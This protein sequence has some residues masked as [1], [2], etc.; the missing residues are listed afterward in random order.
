MKIKILTALTV[1]LALLGA[2]CGWR[3]YRDA[4]LPNRQVTDALNTQKEL[5]EQLRPNIGLTEAPADRALERAARPDD[6]MPRKGGAADENA[7]ARE[8]FAALAEFNPDTVGWLTIDGTAVDY[9]IVQAEDNERYL[10][11][12]FDRRYNYVGCPFLDCRCA[13]GFGGFNAIVYA[14]HIKHE[15]FGDVAKFK[16]SAFMRGHPSAALLTEDGLHTVEFF[17]Y[18]NVPSDSGIYETVFASDEE[19][20]EY[21]DALFAEAVYTAGLT[22]EELKQGGQAHILLLST[23]T[24]EFEEA[25]GVLAGVIR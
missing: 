19:R 9:P 5:L 8:A 10:R 14:H 15:M 18:L 7:A 23:C 25:R 21:I 11:T 1:L 20:A 6:A 22:A 12:G 2:Y 3:Y 24:Y 4:W 16:D 13:E 17:A